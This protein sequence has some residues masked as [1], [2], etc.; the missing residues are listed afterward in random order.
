MSQNAKFYRVKCGEW[1]YPGKNLSQLEENM[2]LLKNKVL[3]KTQ[4]GDIVYIEYL[5][6]QI[7]N[8]W[9]G[10]RIYFDKKLYSIGGNPSLVEIQYLAE[11]NSNSE[12]YI[13][14]LNSYIT[15]IFLKKK[16]SLLDKKILL[17]I[18]ELDYSK[19]FNYERRRYNKKYSELKTSEHDIWD[20]YDELSPSNNELKQLMSQIKKIKKEYQ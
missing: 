19:T 12:D 4:D 14:I 9:N 5:D 13:S 17:K 18:K 3:K 2:K 20:S 1:R 16:K 6:K 10:F 15:N 7:P 8:I 11:N